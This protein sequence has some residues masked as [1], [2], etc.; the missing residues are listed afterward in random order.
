MSSANGS[1]SSRPLP[2]DIRTRLAEIDLDY[3]QGELTQKGYESRRSRILSAM[4]MRMLSLE[5]S[6]AG[7]SV[8][9]G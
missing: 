9:T 5:L 2:A 1:G 4:D 3:Q 6:N 8:G 7:N